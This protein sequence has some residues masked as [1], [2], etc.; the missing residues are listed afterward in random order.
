MSIEDKH[1]IK[2]WT[3]QDALLESYVYA[4]GPAEALPA[5]SHED[6]QLGVSINF[7][8]EYTYRGVRHPVPVGSLNVIHPGEM[9]AARDTEYRHLYADFRKI[10]V[11]PARVQAAAAELTGSKSSLPFFPDPVIF[12]AGLMRLFLDFH[13]TTEEANPLLE[14]ESLLMSLLARSI[15]RYADERRSLLPFKGERE[16]VRRAREYLRDNYAENVSLERLAGVAGL[17]RF[18]FLRAFRREVGLPPHKYQTQVR[19]ERAKLL[20][21]GGA[22]IQHV[23][24]AVG[25]A[26]QS[27]LS[28]HFRRLTQVTPG[29]YISVKRR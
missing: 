14:R 20:L 17:S 23:A 28:R 29:R 3:F 25:F 22:P 26:D 1:T 8:G 27:H 24:Q 13:A 12:D 10:Y 4:P 9:H 11:A 21:A 2:A 19:V 7:P 16:G 6:Y 18:H 15:V 5:H